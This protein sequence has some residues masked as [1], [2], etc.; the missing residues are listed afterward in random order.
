[1]ILSKHDINI[2]VKRSNDYGKDGIRVKN[3]YIPDYLP[4][5]TSD[6]IVHVVWE[7]DNGPTSPSELWEDR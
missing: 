2:L 6:P 5:T 4:A 3:I 7:L 1:M